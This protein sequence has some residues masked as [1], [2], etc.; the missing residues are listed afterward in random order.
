VEIQLSAERRDGQL[1]LKLSNEAR[2]VGLQPDAGA[3]V[4]LANVA[5][6]LVNFYG[7]ASSLSVVQRDGRF[8]VELRLPI[9]LT[10]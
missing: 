1:I 4:G 6:R 8:T 7:T 2:R 3:G 9:E 5:R 10:L